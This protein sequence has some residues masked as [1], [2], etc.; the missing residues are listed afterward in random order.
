[1]TLTFI[2]LNSLLIEFWAKYPD[3]IRIIQAYSD[4]NE[5]LHISCEY[6]A[7]GLM[8]SYFN[9]NKSTVL[10][11]LCI[12]DADLTKIIQEKFSSI[13]ISLP[14]TS[15]LTKDNK[16]YLAQDILKLKNELESQ[17]ILII[18][19][20]RRI[21]L[22]GLVD[23]VKSV[24]KQIEEIKKKYASNIVKLSLELKQARRLFSLKKGIICFL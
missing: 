1:M 13:D 6:G 22:F 11:N 8:I 17:A 19:E 9:K 18:L 21:R 24:E 2:Y 16:S 12:N 14:T 4:L 5:H 20:Q 10:L 15:D 3:C 7:I 23:L